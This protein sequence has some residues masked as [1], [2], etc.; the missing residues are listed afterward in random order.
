MEKIDVFELVI[1]TDDESGNHGIALVDQ[2]AIESNWHMFN[3]QTEYKFNIKDEEKRIIEG[4]AM[5]AGLLIPRIDENGKKFFVKFSAETIA[6]IREKQSKQGLNNNFNLMHD[7]RQPAEGVVML[8]NLIIDNKRGKVA[9]KEF[10][11]VP[12]GSLW[13]SAKI[14]NDEIWSLIKEGRFQGFS[15]EGMY[16]QTESKPMTEKVIDKA[17]EIVQNFEKSVK[18]SIQVTNKKTIDNMSMKV[19]ED[20]KAILFTEEKVEEVAE[21]TE[22]TEKTTEEVTEKFVAAELADGTMINIE[23]GLEEGANVTVEVDGQVN[24]IPDG[25]YPLADGVVISISGGV[26]SAVKEVEA[27]AEEDMNTEVAETPKETPTEQRIRKII[28]STE[29]VF[30]EIKEVKEELAAVKEEFAKYKETVEE[31]NKAIFSAVEEIATEPSVEPT[32]KKSSGFMKAKAKPFA[33][34]LKEEKL[35]KQNK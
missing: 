24:P 17:R 29:T 16:K 31:N 26:I 5:V 6:A 23:P 9:P 18:D 25:D 21:T 14:N 11:K 2:P 4:Y 13:I 28:E 34:R 35:K 8:D 19:I 30:N 20:L 27:E 32:K 22:T 10:E 33:E 15:V 1:D 12:D 7:P 3:K